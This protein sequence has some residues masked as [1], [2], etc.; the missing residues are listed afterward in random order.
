MLVPS[1]FKSH[2]R[3][4][5]KVGSPNYAGIVFFSR[6]KFTQHSFQWSDPYIQ[7]TKKETRVC[8]NSILFG[9]IHPIAL[10]LVYLGP[11]SNF[12]ASC[13][14][15]C[16][17]LCFSC[18]TWYAVCRLVLTCMWEEHASVLYLL[19]LM[20]AAC[21]YIRTYIYTCTC[22]YM[23]ACDRDGWLSM[24]VLMLRPVFVCVCVVLALLF[25][26]W[27]LYLS[28]C[29]V[30]SRDLR[31]PHSRALWCRSSETFSCWFSIF[32]LNSCR[33]MG[34][35]Y[36]PRPFL[37]FVTFWCG[38]ALLAAVQ[39]DPVKHY[40]W[41][42]GF[43]E[44]QHVARFSHTYACEIEEQ[45]CTCYEISSCMLTCMHVQQACTSCMLQLSE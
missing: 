32:L 38:A 26:H 2:Q 36:W 7:I 28:Y 39:Q 4:N 16:Y 15:V 41:M 23:L 9:H 34:D 3:P 30:M 31:R 12:S 10:Q 42:S 14:H 11:T 33:C 37:A 40:N 45:L 6:P 29:S 17:S 19:L 44:M 8:C 5:R 13:M 24:Y 25:T 27:S 35:H 1:D 43:D 21:I 22:M 20:L 18:L